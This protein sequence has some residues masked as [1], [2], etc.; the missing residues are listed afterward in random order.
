MYKNMCSMGNKHED[1]ELWQKCDIVE[2]LEEQLTWLGCWNGWEAQ[3][4]IS[5]I[6]FAFW[7]NNLF[8]IDINIHKEREVK[9]QRT[10]IAPTLASA[11]SCINQLSGLI[12]TEKLF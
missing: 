7:I 9:V 8:F 12:Q 6:I 11:L 10:C 1:L 5:G 4:C 3:R 2:L